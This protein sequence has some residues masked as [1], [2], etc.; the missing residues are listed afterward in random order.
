MVGATDW[1]WRY[2]CDH[3]LDLEIWL[4]PQT[5]LGGMIVTTDV[6]WAPVLI[7]V[8]L[9]MRACVFVCVCVLLGKHV[10]VGRRWGGGGGRWGL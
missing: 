7:F 6:I 9:S 8:F 10:C 3:R 4:E 1:I 5:G 2:D